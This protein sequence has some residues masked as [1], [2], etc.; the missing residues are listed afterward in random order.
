M[1]EKRGGNVPPRFSRREALL[2]VFLLVALLLLV[3]LILL[4]LT[5]LLLVLVVLRHE[6]PPPFSYQ[7]GCGSKRKRRLHP[8]R[9]Y[10]CQKDGKYSG[11]YKK[12]D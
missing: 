2:P 12:D 4:V 5:V 7:C 1:I 11:K 9:G 10:S 6:G 3:L 8:Y